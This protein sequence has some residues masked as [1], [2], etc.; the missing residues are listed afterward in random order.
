MAK[1]GGKFGFGKPKG[2]KG[3][4]HRNSEALPKPKV[5]ATQPK[6]RKGK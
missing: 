5:G 2:G 3:G 1:K 6:G 4:D